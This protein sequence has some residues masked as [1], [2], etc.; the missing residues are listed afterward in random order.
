MLSGRHELNAA[1][2]NSTGIGYA[3]IIYYIL[4]SLIIQSGRLRLCNDRSATPHAMLVMS[5]DVT[6]SCRLHSSDIGIVCALIPS[7]CTHVC[8]RSHVAVL[9]CRPITP[10]QM[11]TAHRHKAG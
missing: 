7:V 2:D 11:T 1:L 6:V 4:Q 5:H 8:A 10:E 3:L 9:W